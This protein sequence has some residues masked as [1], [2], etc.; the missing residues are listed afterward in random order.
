MDAVATGTFSAPRRRPAGG[1]T[2]ATPHYIQIE[3]T[4]L[5]DVSRYI[6]RAEQ[7]V[8]RRNFDHA[9]ALYREILNLD[10]DCG[11]AR[12]GA[13]RAAFK[14]FE[15]RYPSAVERAALNL[16]TYLLLPFASLL[17]A[18]Q[19]SANLCE[20]ALRRDPKNPRLNHRLGHALLRLGHRNGALAAFEVV[21]EFDQRDAESLKILG[22]LYAEQKEL[23]KALDC[24]ERALKINPRDQ[25]AGKQRKDLA[26]LTAIHRG[27]YEQA[28][29]ARD[30]A[31]SERQ[32]KDAERS[33]K[34]V[35]SSDDVA[36]AIKELREEL[37]RTP[38]DASLATKVARL[39]LQA[40]N[41]KGAEEA[42]LA[43][44][45][46][47]PGHAELED[48][49][50]D[51]RLAA[52][53]REF[54]SAEAEERKGEEGALD[55]VRRLRRQL[56]SL[57]IEEF[58]RRSRNHP[59]DM[60]L[61][62][63]LG[64][65]LLEADDVDGAIEQFQQ[66]VKDPKHKVKAQQLL[67]TAFARKGL[68]DMAGK[69]LREAADRIA[70]MTDQR[71]EILYELARVFEQGGSSGDALNVYKEIYEADISYRDVGQRIEALRAG[72]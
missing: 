22:R 56:L 41:P 45:Q 50:G 60:G 13:R 67:G 19:W 25:E 33:A 30:L 44:L 34:I 59:T 14:K 28:T 71:K 48:L 66:A 1:R 37:A 17:R 62:F 27:G 70:G 10:P 42:A 54:S 5:V 52:L 12:T 46:E 55:R 11:P 18:H 68:W 31:R 53:E 26:A 3:G 43:G 35:R 6:E 49:L 23:D 63:R 15:K 47:N 69:Q 36:E 24:Y 2:R 9:I 38:G 65:H 51:A 7:E 29:H 57:Q 40:R 64:R 4:G 20:N 61:R 58:G 8:K 16:P 21:A 72:S 39:E 32:L